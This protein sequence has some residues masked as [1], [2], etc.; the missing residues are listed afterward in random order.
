MHNILIYLKHY[1]YTSGRHDYRGVKVEKEEEYCLIRL[2]LAGLTVS[3]PELTKTTCFT[4]TATAMPK[5]IVMPNP[6]LPS[7]H[8]RSLHGNFYLE[9]SCT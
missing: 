4:I 6:L 1:L 5:P 2:V 7:F 8:K 3:E 9:T